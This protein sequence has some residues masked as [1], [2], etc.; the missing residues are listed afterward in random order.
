MRGGTVVECKNSW[1]S[2]HLKSFAFLTVPYSFLESLEYFAEF[3]ES[4]FQ[5]L[6][7]RDA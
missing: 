6:C 7:C 4:N 2:E 3:G 1:S 5:G